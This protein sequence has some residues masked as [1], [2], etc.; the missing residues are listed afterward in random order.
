M[1]HFPLL[2]SLDFRQGEGFVP[3]FPSSQ[4]HGKEITFL[5]LSSPT[6]PPHHPPAGTILA[7]EGTLKG[8]ADGSDLLYQPH[9]Q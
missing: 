8:E 5:F 4:T 7:W 6:R 1:L 3:S 2:S 9:H